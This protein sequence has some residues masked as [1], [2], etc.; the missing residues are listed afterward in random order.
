MKKPSSNLSPDETRVSPWLSLINAEKGF[1]WSAFAWS[2]TQFSDTVYSLS[3]LI[4]FF[5]EVVCIY[6]HLHMLASR[7]LLIYLFVSLINVVTDF[8]KQEGLL[9]KK[10]FTCNK[11]SVLEAVHEKWHKG[12]GSIGSISSLFHFFLMLLLINK[13]WFYC[14]N[15]TRRGLWGFSSVFNVSCDRETRT[16]LIE[17]SI[18]EL[19]LQDT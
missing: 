4:S 13:H 10:Q 1:H 5:I 8:I 12:I 18:L 6:I 2:R 7:F 15:L 9:V 3:Y 16:L 11:M 17:E 19:C 14:F